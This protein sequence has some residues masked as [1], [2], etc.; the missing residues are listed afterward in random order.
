MTISNQDFIN[1][2]Y[3]SSFGLESFSLSLEKTIRMKEEVEKKKG[4]KE[5]VGTLNMR[6]KTNHYDNLR[7]DEINKQACKFS[8]IVQGLQTQIHH[9]IYQKFV[10]ECEKPK[11]KD[12]DTKSFHSTLN[13]F[14]QIL[15][16]TN[17]LTKSTNVHDQDNSKLIKRV[18]FSR[19]YS[20]ILKIAFDYYEPRIHGG[21]YVKKLIMTLDLYLTLLSEHAGN[22]VLKVRTNKRVKNKLKM[23]QR[24]LRNK[25]KASE[26][27]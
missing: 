14:Y 17:T 19:D 18:I 21:A 7:G 13:M 20:R 16:V 4:T 8:Y 27:Q 15:R 24:K 6:E 26:G 3:V 9:L 1:F 11:K 12:F 25:E 23:K 2:F 5:A 10:Q 22:R